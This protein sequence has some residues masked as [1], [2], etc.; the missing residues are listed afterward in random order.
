MTDTIFDLCRN[1]GRAEYNTPGALY[2]PELETSFLIRCLRRTRYDEGKGRLRRH[3]III[4]PPDTVKSS[5][6]A[7]FLKKYCGAV[8][9]IGRT[10]ADMGKPTYLELQGGSTWEA[11]RG[12]YAEGVFTHPQLHDV[13]FLYASEF[14]AFFG[15]TPNEMMNKIDHMNVALEEGVVTFNQK[16]A[17]GAPMKARQE[18][19]GWCATN[20]INF[21]I[22]E[23][24]YEY[25]CNAMA[26][27]C[28]RPFTDK[29]EKAVDHSGFLG[30]NSVV[31]WDP[32]D[33]EIYEYYNEQFGDPDP[34]IIERIRTFNDYAWKST[35]DHVPAPPRD[36]VDSL[37]RQVNERYRRIGL[38][39]GRAFY[40][41]RP[42]RDRQ[43]ITQ[44]LT[45]FC[46]ARH[47]EKSLATDASGHIDELRYSIE[48]AQSV[49]RHYEAIVEMIEKR[50]ELQGS[51]DPVMDDAMRCLV[52]FVAARG[53]KVEVHCTENYE[54]VGTEKYTLFKQPDFVDALKAAGNSRQAAYRRIAKLR[55]GGH[56]SLVE[57]DGRVM[58]FRVADHVIEDAGFYTRLEIE[59]GLHT[60]MELLHSLEEHMNEDGVVP[61]GHRI[62]GA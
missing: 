2:M 44:L 8:S 30:R 5:I 54:V 42:K 10:E 58:V 40:S 20:G 47:L 61:L 6:T 9:R 16:T 27:F 12:G 11:L 56:I 41:V 37:V 45:A 33:L 60:D 4:S 39:T 34:E 46:F 7:E 28:T 36:M 43:N 26:V 48:D 57:N 25:E 49:R 38:R 14:F 62:A 31:R 55:E 59:E 19:A 53:A 51:D 15:H 18:F 1:A 32:D 52:D 50:A 22:D 3:L 21:D 29:Q 35:V 13:D 17:K 23:C 24:T